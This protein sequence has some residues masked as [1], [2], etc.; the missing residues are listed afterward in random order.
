MPEKPTTMDGLWEAIE[1]VWKEIPQHIV[2]G[3]IESFEERRKEVVAAH[4]GST[5]F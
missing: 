2:D 5:Q 4:S 1:K 3:F